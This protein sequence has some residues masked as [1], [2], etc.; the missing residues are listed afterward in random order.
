MAGVVPELR[1]AGVDVDASWEL[2]R[3]RDRAVEA[4][5]RMLYF[6]HDGDDVRGYAER[7]VALDP[8]NPEARSLL[9]KVAERMAWDADAAFRAGSPGVAQNLL[10]ECR[11]VIPDYPRCEAVAAGGM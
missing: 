1:N 4:Q 3:L 7:M 2:R 11:A 10:R 6:G 5:A 9:R 8:D